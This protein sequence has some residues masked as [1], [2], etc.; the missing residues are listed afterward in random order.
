MVQSLSCGEA[1]AVH[2]SALGIGSENEVAREE[3]GNLLSRKS[4]RF[5]LLKLTIF[6]QPIML[7]THPV[8]VLKPKGV[9][10][11]PNFKN[12]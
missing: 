2:L 9:G 12:T 3:T 10:G 8:R 1:A 11:S 4:H 6:L 7:S 5:R